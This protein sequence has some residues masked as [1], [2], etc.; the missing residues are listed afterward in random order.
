LFIRLL[1][2]KCLDLVTEGA[3]VLKHRIIFIVSVVVLLVLGAV[4]YVRQRNSLLAAPLEK[5]LVVTPVPDTDIPLPSLTPLASPTRSVLIGPYVSQQAPDFTLNTLDGAVIQL[6]DHRENVV[7]LNFWTSW[8]IPCKEEMPVIQAAYEKYQDRGLVVL[9]I[10][11]TDLDEQEAIIQFVRETGVTFPILLDESGSVS[12]DYRVIS[13][14][15]SFFIDRSG[16][17]RH[18]QLGAMTEAQLEQY[19]DE[20]LR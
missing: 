16:I 19:L 20:M 2:R 14:P 1:A 18:F 5:N 10:N 15:T 11:M 12:T 4:W 13:I 7:L 3:P 9:G 6:K 17:I 8:C